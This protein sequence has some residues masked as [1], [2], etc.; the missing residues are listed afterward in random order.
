MVQQPKLVV[1]DKGS[2][3]RVS[4]GTQGS[5]NRT[6]GA[7][8]KNVRPAAVEPAVANFAR[9]V[10]KGKRLFL[11]PEVGREGIKR[12]RLDAGEKGRVW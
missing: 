7:V 3:E 11:R 2:V 8:A 10:G 1:R 5:P 6:K 9:K 4:I 12:R